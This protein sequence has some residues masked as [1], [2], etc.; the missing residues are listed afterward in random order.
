[1]FERALANKTAVVKKD[2]E[3]YFCYVWIPTIR[4]VIEN[5]KG[6]RGKSQK[7]NF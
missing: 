6:E 1:M 7:P 4:R 2:T 3:V 5:S